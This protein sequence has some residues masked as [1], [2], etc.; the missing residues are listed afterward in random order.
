MTNLSLSA[1][2]A[3]SNGFRKFDNV[4][5]FKLPSDQ[6]SSVAST[7]S[8]IAA[9]QNAAL[10]LLG[11]KQPV[12]EAT[13]TAATAE[14]KF[15]EPDFHAWAVPQPVRNWA[16]TSM[17]N[18]VAYSPWNGMPN[19]A[20][21]PWTHTSQ[22]TGSLLQN[23]WGNPNIST[24]QLQSA[25]N[26]TLTQA[27]AVAR[28]ANPLQGNF[29]NSHANLGILH[30]IV[31]QGAHPTGWTTPG[32]VQNNILQAANT[33][34]I[35]QRMNPMLGGLD[36]EGFWLLARDSGVS[37]SAATHTSFQNLASSDPWGFNMQ[38]VITPRDLQARGIPL[39]PDGRFPLDVFARV[40]TAAN[41]G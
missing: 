9:S 21:A 10:G 7:S 12:V 36:F 4:A 38:H 26:L 14:T 25:F 2:P 8:D 31:S 32:Q 22:I 30:N 13:S 15:A 18:P 33:G 3:N 17:P 28:L 34:N 39:T 16:G 37:P 24:H 5:E 29:Q 40:A 6:A 35:N 41:W 20:T 19:S 23:N 1:A 27:G 11:Q